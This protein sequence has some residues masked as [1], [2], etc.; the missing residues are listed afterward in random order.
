MDPALETQNVWIHQND[1]PENEPITCPSG[2]FMATF[3]DDD[4]CF[5]SMWD[6]DS[7]PGRVQKTPLWP[8][9][10]SLLVSC[11]MPQGSSHLVDPT[12]DVNTNLVFNGKSYWSCRSFFRGFLPERSGSLSVGI[13]IIRYHPSHMCCTWLVHDSG[14]HLLMEEILHHLGC[15]KPCNNGINYFSTGEGFL[16]YSISLTWITQ[17]QKNAISSISLLFTTVHCPE[18]KH[19]QK[20]FPT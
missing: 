17:D 18:K 5:F 9:I 6:M 14:T 2:Y 4:V 7:L 13:L 12:W 19:Y 1:P 16:P 3:E 8:R 20:H 11:F 10:K 15:I